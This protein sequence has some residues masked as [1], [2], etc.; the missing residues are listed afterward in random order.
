MIFENFVLVEFQV[1]SRPF[2][3]CVKSGA[4]GSLLSLRP[5]F[6]FVLISVLE[7]WNYFPHCYYVFLHFNTGRNIFLS[8]LP[9]LGV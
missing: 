9:L 4:R 1:L 5:D 8:N 7:A 3:L 2:W 6:L